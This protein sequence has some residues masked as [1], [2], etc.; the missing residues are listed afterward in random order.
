MGRGLYSSEGAAVGE[1]PFR[2]AAV[3]VLAMASV[4]ALLVGC[5]GLPRLSAASGAAGQ[6]TSAAVAPATNASS[7]ATATPEA[8]AASPVRSGPSGAA[9]DAIR[10]VIQRGNEEEVQAV[11]TQD[12]TVMRDTATAAYYNQLTQTFND[13]VNSGVTAIQLV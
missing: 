7:G 4:A 13:L 8:T 9:T 2:R 5:S 6:A 12:A 10:S 3:R 11:A 1:N